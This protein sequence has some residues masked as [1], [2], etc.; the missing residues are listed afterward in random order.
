VFVEKRFV[1]RDARM[2]RGILER[3]TCWWCSGVML[4]GVVFGNLTMEASFNRQFSSFN[5]ECSACFR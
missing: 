5:I 1:G 3:Q 4:V 2:A